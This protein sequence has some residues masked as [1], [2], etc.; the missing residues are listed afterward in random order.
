[1]KKMVDER[2]TIFYTLIQTVMSTSSNSEKTVLIVLCDIGWSKS[3]G[4]IALREIDL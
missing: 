4:L 3:A 2:D 1:M